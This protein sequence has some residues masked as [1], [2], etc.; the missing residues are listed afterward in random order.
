[1]SS[2]VELVVGGK[3]QIVRKIGAGSFG[4]VFLGK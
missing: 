1:M 3:Y 2:R 4:E